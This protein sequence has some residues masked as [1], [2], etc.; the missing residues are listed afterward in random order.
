MISDHFLLF[1][2][3]FENLIDFLHNDIYFDE[4]MVISEN[5]EDYER[6]H[7]MLQNVHSSRT[8][9]I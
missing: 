7:V 8:A 9:Y 2:D 4:G 6:N 1:F 5:Y 3:N